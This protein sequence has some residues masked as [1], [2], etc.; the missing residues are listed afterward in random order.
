MSTLKERINKKLEFYEKKQS[1]V[2]RLRWQIFHYVRLTFELLAYHCPWNSW[3]CFFHE[4]RGLKIG[5]GVYLGRA[6]IFD[7]NFTDQISIGDNSSIGDKSF[8]VAHAATPNEAKNKSYFETIKK[9]KIGKGV[10]IMPQVIIYPGVEIGDGCL[11]LSG[12][13][14]NR[15]VPSGSIVKPPESQ[16]IKMP[17][18]MRQSE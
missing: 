13:I 14:V 2:N 9:V 17:E 18:T 7:R 11:V 10:W 12:S 1:F 5:K 15:N 3:R 16:I 6:I 4:C 8:I